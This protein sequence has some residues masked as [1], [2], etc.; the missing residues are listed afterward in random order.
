MDERK[1]HLLE[2]IQSDFTYHTP[3]HELDIITMVNLRVAA[4][5]LAH[6]MVSVCPLGRELST[7]LTKLEEAVMHANAG[8]AR[9]PPTQTIEPAGIVSQAQV[10]KLG[11]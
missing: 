7:A 5:N 6:Q 1:R 9:K 10:G 8:I 2:R 4:G 11:T 3:T